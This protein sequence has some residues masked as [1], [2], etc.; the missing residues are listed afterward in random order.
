MLQRRMKEEE[1]VR[2][3]AYTHQSG[4]AHEFEEG[5]LREVRVHLNLVHGG[6]YCAALIINKSGK[7][8][9]CDTFARLEQVHH[10]RAREV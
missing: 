9:I 3:N 5:G 6:R 1:R 4:T 7:Q 8:N 2:N 10:K